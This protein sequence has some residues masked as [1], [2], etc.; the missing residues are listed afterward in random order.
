[1]DFNFTQKEEAFRNEVHEYLKKEVP[2]WYEGFWVLPADV[3][4]RAFQF[5]TEFAKKLAKKG[6][7]I[8]S[9]PMEYGGQAASPMEQLIF[10][11]EMAYFDEPRGPHYMGATWLGPTILRFGTEEQKKQHLPAIANASAIWCEGLSEPDA[12]SDLASL[13]TRA[14]EAG[15]FYVVNGQKT[16]T[17]YAHHADW[18]I[19]GARTDPSLPKH[20]GI[21]CF[22]MDMRSPGVTVR[23]IQSIFGHH[24]NEMYLDNVKIPEANMFGGKNQGWYTLAGT[25]DIERSGTVGSGWCKRTLDELVA[26][27]RQAMRNGKPLSKDP[28]VRQKLAEAAIEVETYRMLLYRVVW[29]D[30]IG[31]APNTEASMSKL[32][33][34][35]VGVR[36]AT[37]G[38]EILSLLGVLVYGTPWVQL[39]GRIERMHRWSMHSTVA[40]GSSEIQRNVIATRGLGLPRQ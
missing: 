1:M 16:W 34:S 15:D 33:G 14:E 8:R 28:V 21:T 32:F 38:M 24:L 7:L 40:G 3:E 35:E 26:Y 23:P 6:W 29:M 2:D 10:A 13:Q 37:T 4:E 31:L 17:S 30:S 25:L 9:W 22:L 12:G 5:N 20:K 19:L 36:L 18:C 27:T 39:R 11:E